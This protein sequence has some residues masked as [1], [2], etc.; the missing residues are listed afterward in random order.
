MIRSIL[1]KLSMLITTIGAVLALGWP[2]SEPQPNDQ[3]VSHDK[4]ESPVKVE[5]AKDRQFVK[6]RKGYSLHPTT[7]TRANLKAPESLPSESQVD[8]NNSTARQLEALPGIG[9]VIAQRI[10]ERRSS[11]GEFHSP[12]DLRSVKGLGPKRIDKLRPLIRFSP[13]SKG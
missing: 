6:D 5:V 10:I 2:W 11:V 13:A 9:R 4:V 8:V 12:D 1:I 3:V 7:H